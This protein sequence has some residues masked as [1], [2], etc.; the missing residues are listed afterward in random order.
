MSDYKEN[1]GIVV[2]MDEEGIEHEFVLI[3]GLEIGSAHYVLLAEDEESDDVFAFSVE[4]S[5][6]G[7]ILVP[8]ESD[9]ELEL[10]EETYDQLFPDND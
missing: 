1:D 5:D 6:D 4:E 2:L 8:V 9:E 3:T 10:I 7:E